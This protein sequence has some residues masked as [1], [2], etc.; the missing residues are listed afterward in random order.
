MRIARLDIR[1]FRGVRA[2]TLRLG[3]HTV[4]VGPNNI[5]KTT[6]IEAL[7]LL[8]GRDRLVRTL[9]EHDFFG[10]TP[11]EESRII[12]FATLSDFEADDP[13]LHREW[14]NID[15]GGVEK[16]LDPATGQLHDQ[17]EEPS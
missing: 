2:G 3:N 12:I 10:S 17:R 15:R 1:Q 7:A 14:F 11:T 9:T 16:W 13:N 6:I 5:G 8:F 4:L